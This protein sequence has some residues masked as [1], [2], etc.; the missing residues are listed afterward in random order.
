[1]SQQ[2]PFNFDPPIWLKKLI[3]TSYFLIIV[4]ILVASTL[5]FV[6]C[7]TYVKPYEYGIKQI[8]IGLKRGIKDKIYT[9]GLHFVMPFGFEEMHHFPK[10]L[11]NLD[12]T[13]H[14]TQ[15]T[16]TFNDKAAN[17]QTSDGFFVEV[18][19]SILFRINDPLKVIKTIGP[20]DLYF[21]NGLLPK[22]EPVLK[23]T[24]GTLTTEEFYNPHLRTEKM[25]LAQ[26]KLNKELANKGIAIDQ[27]LI[28]Y[29]KYSNE[30]QRNIEEKKLKDQLVF[31]NQAEARA[32]MEAAIVSKII[33]EGEMSV[34][35]ELEKGKGYQQR[36]SGERELYRRK[37]K[38]NANLLVKRAEAEKVRL[39][40]N[41]LQGLGSNNLVGL[42]MAK[43]LNGIELIILPSNGNKG[44]NPFNLEKTRLLFD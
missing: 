38:A 29:F 31:K 39:K 21:Y 32:A 25:A 22:A 5:F 18:D 3:N 12:L 23:E 35:I 41:A 36:K 24:L 34:Q 20:G 37:I 7:F 33:E 16:S 43:V 27:V 17:I 11:L 28:R 6:T 4:G 15:N 2:A 30:I 10:S 42:E 13:N 9:P 19:V 44:F 40:N 26:K 8:N 1:M 14:S